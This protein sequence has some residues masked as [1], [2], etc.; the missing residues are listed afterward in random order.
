MLEP[1]KDIIGESLPLAD[2]CD[3]NLCLSSA[4]E[5]QFSTSTV[6]E[7]GILFDED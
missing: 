6:K 5:A 4:L 1:E 2:P 7:R 3:T